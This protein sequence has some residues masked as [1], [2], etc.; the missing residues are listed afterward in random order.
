MCVCEQTS[1]H[2]NGTPVPDATL[3]SLFQLV[4]RTYLAVAFKSDRQMNHIFHD[5]ETWGKYLDWV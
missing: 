4:I 1:R 3:I 5:G 2:A